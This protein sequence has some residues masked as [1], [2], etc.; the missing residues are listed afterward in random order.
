V[1][2]LPERARPVLPGEEHDDAANFL[3]G[4]ATI[5]ILGLVG[6]AAQ[7]VAIT[8]IAFGLASAT[9]DN[10]SKGL[11]YELPATAVAQLVRDMQRA[12]KGALPSG[13]YADRPSA[14]LALRGYI[15][16]CLPVNIETQVANALK[17]AKP[18]VK[19][20]DSSLPPIVQIGP[21]ITTTY[22]VDE[23]T[24][25]L[26]SWVYK[27]DRITLIPEN[28]TRLLAAMS[29]AGLPPTVSIAIFLSSGEYRTQRAAVAKDLNL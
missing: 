12:Y 21:I 1:R 19:A 13:G 11:I 26:S 24:R 25:V 23:N 16:I 15:E 9:V 10:V 27:N 5:G 14:F 4:A 2:R 8:G 6:A 17:I 3:T 28:R 18:E 7:A 22:G 29:R 20:G